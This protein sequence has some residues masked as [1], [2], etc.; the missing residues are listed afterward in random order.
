MSEPAPQSAGAVL[1]AYLTRHSDALRA[2]AGRLRRSEPDAAHRMRVAAR[3]MRS[4]LGTFGD[5]LDPDWTGSVR[6]ELRWL[7]GVL[8]GER[9]RE[10]TLAH[11]RDA[12]AGLGPGPGADRARVLLE[13]RLAADLV[14]AHAEAVRTLGSDRYQ[15]LADGLAARSAAL[16]LGP[17]AAGPATST[18]APLV[19]Q[20]YQRLARGTR[21]L[22]LADL[23]ETA[24]VAAQGQ[25]PGPLTPRQLAGLSADLTAR[26][27]DAGDDEPWHR[28]RILA[29]RARY[30]AEAV[31]PAFGPPA[32]AFAALMTEVTEMIGTH[33]DASVAAQVIVDAASTPRVTAATAF[34]LG[35]LYAGQRAVVARVRVEFALRW[36]RLGD[37]DARRWL[38]V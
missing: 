31:A 20:T 3:R 2:Q 18:L 38:K 28:V 4:A 8:A 25:P 22:P 24:R 33:Q 17:A 12:L 34:D 32:T 10:V 15:A 11:L 1:T 21:A 13:R 36:P 30:A 7:A 23:A 29:K 16:P 19:R 35:I 6:A 26:R 14:A 37:R 5:L 27:I 9:D